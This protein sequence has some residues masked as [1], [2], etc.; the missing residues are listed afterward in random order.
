MLL[1][2]KNLSIDFETSQGLLKA[3]RQLSF[4]LEQG[5]T[6]GVVGESGCGKSITNLALMGLLPP[7]AQLCA[8][9]M[10]FA[11]NDLLSLR[12][13]DWQRL[14]GKDIA[15]IFQDPMSALNPCFSIGFQI[16]ETLKIHHPEMTK[17]KRRAR[18]LELLESVGIPDPQ[19]R[20]KAYAHELSGGMSQRVMI[21]MAIA[22]NPKLLIA[23]EPT[24]ALDVTIQDQILTL[25]KDIQKENHMGLIFVTHDLGVVTRI[26]DQIQV[27][28]AGEI[29][30]KG[31]A[32][33]LINSPQHPYT[34]GLLNSLPSRQATSFRQKLPSIPGLVP[35]LT[36]RPSGCQF[37]PR[38]SYS[39]EECLHRTP[40]LVSYDDRLVRCPFPKSTTE[41]NPRGK[42]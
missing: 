28:Y 41:P 5:E 32:Q 16:E 26:A 3:V 18:V 12:E 23:D 30:E 29:V 20:T 39:Q 6:L 36:H 17:K 40:M 19:E 33:K 37:S 21:A 22:S 14:R 7:T 13:K 4:Q 34:E 11:G 25:L 24:T 42:M 35:N 2:I 31:A 38:C 10:Q 8:D 1:E 15:M 27:M 9:K